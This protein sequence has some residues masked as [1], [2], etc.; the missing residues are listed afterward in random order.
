MI[1]RLIIIGAILL[2]LMV[3]ANAFSPELSGDRNLGQEYKFTVNN[4]TTPDQ[5][6]RG[7]GVTYHW[8]VYDYRILGRAYSYYS[9]D[10]GRWFIQHAD[11]EKKYLALW[12][13]VWMEGGSSWYGWGPDRFRLWVWD[14]TTIHNET[15]HI[16]D[17]PIEYKSDQY[18]PVVIAELQ[19][20]NGRSDKKL[21]SREWYGWKDEIELIRQEPGP[22]NAWDGFI[23]Y[24]IPAAATENDI[25]VFASSWYGYGV[26]YLA[27]HQGLKQAKPIT[28]VANKTQ[29]Q[30]A[31][32]PRGVKPTPTMV[33][34]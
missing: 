4:V 15:I 10:W 23:M 28:L 21:L 31:A 14:N 5:S 18:R 30:P 12:V 22:S 33:I 32:L 24:Q 25:R 27:P 7:S 17:L 11:H 2:I 9:N 19:N 34:R 29:E 26:W 8:S 20:L 1:P 16:N 6:L 3:P 13:R